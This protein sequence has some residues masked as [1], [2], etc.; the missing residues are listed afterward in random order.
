MPV[1]WRGGIDRTRDIAPTRE[2]VNRHVATEP[3][4]VEGRADA[5]DTATSIVE[6]AAVATISIA[7]IS[8]IAIGGEIF[9]E[10]ALRKS[11]THS[12]RRIDAL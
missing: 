2:L 1:G 12:E 10:T 5:S 4:I 6:I 8:Y 3:V 7:D 11:Y 9:T